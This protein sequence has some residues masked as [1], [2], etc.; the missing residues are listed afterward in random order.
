M[1]EIAEEL[2]ISEGGVFTILHENLS[3]RKQCLKWVLRFLTVN[4]KQQSVDDSEC[5]LQLFEPNKN[6]LLRKYVAM[7]EPW[8]H[9]FTQKSN[10]Q[11]AE[12]TV[13]SEILPKPPNGMRKVFC[14]FL[15]KEEPSIANIILHYWCNY[16][17]TVL[18]T[19]NFQNPK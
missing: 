17:E 7:D 10:W 11:S 1:R 3:M 4:Q 14:S 2:K 16:L 19:I 8:I 13:A 18:G 12:W 5:C 9:H 6:E 15:R